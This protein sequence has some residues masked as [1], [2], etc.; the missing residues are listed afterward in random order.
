MQQFE[1]ALHNT[2]FARCAVYGDVVEDYSL[3]VMHEREVVLVNLGGIAVRKV[4]VP[5]LSGLNHY[6]IYVVALLVEEGVD[7]LCR[8]NGHVVF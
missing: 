5:I 6:E 8:A 7:A 2:V 4:Y 3:A 1:V